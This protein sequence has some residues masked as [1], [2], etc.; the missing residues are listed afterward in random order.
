LA[1]IYSGTNNLVFAG[2]A[3]GLGASGNAVSN[4]IF[5]GGVLQYNG[6]N[7]ST[8]R[9]F[10]INQPAVLDVGNAYSVLTLGGNY[11]TPASEEIYSLTKR[12]EGTLDMRGTA[13]GGYGLSAL[14][15]D[16][17]TLRLSPAFTD[18]Y[19]R[20][21]VGALILAGG[22]LEVQ[23]VTG[24]NTTQNMIGTL[25]VLEG[26]SVIRVIGSIADNT[27]TLLNLQ[28]VNNASSVSFQK[29]RHRVV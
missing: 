18:Q 25:Q 14:V 13:F 22:I 21:D 1:A 2:T 23:S 29:G 6:T 10:T 28:D 24:R 8:D 27:F 20:N 26:A 15:V 11:T 7:A 17:G 9:G 4:L 19:I 16:D 3:S 12:G 5:N